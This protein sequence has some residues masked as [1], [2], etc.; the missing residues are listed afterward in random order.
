MSG[1]SR[2]HERI[3]PVAGKTEPIGTGR[4]SPTIEA[5][6]EQQAGD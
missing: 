2:C 4:H 6:V 1:D 5:S 3:R